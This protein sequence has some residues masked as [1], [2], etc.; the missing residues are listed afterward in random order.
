MDNYA[1]IDAFKGRN[2]PVT[3]QPVHMS[4]WRLFNQKTLQD[5]FLIVLESAWKREEVHN[6]SPRQAQD[7]WERLKRWWE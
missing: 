2:S 4:L 7:K 1:L 5:V 6:L 3:K